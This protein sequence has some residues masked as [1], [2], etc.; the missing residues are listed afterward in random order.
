MAASRTQQLP[1]PLIGHITPTEVHQLA[2]ALGRD[3]LPP[4]PTNMRQ[5]LVDQRPSWD[6]VRM[7]VSDPNQPQRVALIN[8]RRFQISACPVG[9]GGLINRQR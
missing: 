9:V 8:P 5:G 4:E 3:A 7:G 1:A 2:P 6:L